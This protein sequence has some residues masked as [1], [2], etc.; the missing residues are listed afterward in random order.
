MANRGLAEALAGAGY[1]LD[2]AGAQADFDVSGWLSTMLTRAPQPWAVRAEGRT[3]DV[4]ALLGACLAR[5]AADA[6]ALAP[7]ITVIC[8]G[9]RPQPV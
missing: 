8:Q 9:L 4:K 2:A 6:A 7:V 1:E 5:D 3:G